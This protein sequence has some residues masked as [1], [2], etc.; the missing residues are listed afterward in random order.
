M[1]R[2]LAAFSRQDEVVELAREIAANAPLAVRAAKR[3]VRGGAVLPVAEISARIISYKESLGTVEIAVPRA[4]ASSPI[5][6]LVVAS[7]NSLPYLL[8]TG[9][10][11][12]RILACSAAA[13]S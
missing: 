8:S 3:S 2:W 11:L 6:S 12:V 13:A 10:S 5:I 7:P 9:C 1:P 4:L